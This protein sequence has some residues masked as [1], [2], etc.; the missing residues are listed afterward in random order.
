MGTESRASYSAPLASRWRTLSASLCLGLGTARNCRKNLLAFSPAEISHDLKELKAIVWMLSV[1]SAETWP[2]LGK[3]K[4][5]WWTV[6][7]L[8]VQV[9]KAF[10]LEHPVDTDY[11][12]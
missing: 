8:T 6:D 5:P 3:E 11:P 9:N 7:L 12:I 1:F 4:S 2:S 10:F